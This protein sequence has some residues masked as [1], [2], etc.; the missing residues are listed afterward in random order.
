MAV[1]V[2]LGEMSPFLLMFLRF[3]IAA[4]VLWVI[5]EYSRRGRAIDRAD[6][7]KFLGLGL[8]AVPFNQGLFMYGLQWTTTSHSALLYSLTPL[9]VMLI[10]Q[11]RLGERVTVGRVIGVLLAFA[12]VLLVLLEGGL[13]LAP[14]QFTGDMLVLLAVVAWAYFSVLS[15]PL[16]LKYGAMVV[17]ARAMTYGTLL[18]FPI[19]VWSL[20]DFSPSSVSPAAWTGLLYAAIATSVIFYTVWNW[21]MGHIEA[22]RVAVFNN[23]Q[24]V[25]A[26]LLG[27]WLLNEP[28]SPMFIGAGALVVLG[29][30]VTE[31]L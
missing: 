23:I 6:Q 20:A 31:V 24:P 2:A 19:G 3:S 29:V 12:G 17:T 5:G 25:V 10:A 28:I 14:G 22:A 16:I 8:L 27:W 18:F 13:H 15:K 4:S 9:L 11:R 30:V 21:A 1:K 7:W 26:A